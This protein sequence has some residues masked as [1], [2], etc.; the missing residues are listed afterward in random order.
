MY[1]SA[2][3]CSF[4]LALPVHHTQHRIKDTEA[5]HKAFMA[6]VKTDNKKKQLTCEAEYA[7]L[8]IP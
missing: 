3:L 6:C 1:S 4:I 8:Y 5:Q 7:R 2:I